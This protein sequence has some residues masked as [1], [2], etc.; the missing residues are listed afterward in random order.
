MFSSLEYQAVVLAGG[1][2]TRMSELTASKPKCLLPIGSYPMIWYSL[3]MLKRIGFKEVIVITLDSAKTEITNLPK[4]F[5][6]ELTLDVVTIPAL[7][8]SGSISSHGEEFGT[9]DAIRLIH[10][11]L[12]A[13]RIMVVSSDLVTDVQLRHLTDL[14]SVHSSSLTALF[15]HSVLDHKSVEVP[16]PK[17]KPKKERDFVGI[18]HANSQ[19]C[20]FKSEADVDGGVLSL[21]RKILQEHP[22]I[23]MYN[24]LLDAHFYIF[25]KWVCDFIKAD[26]QISTIKG[27]L[28]P[29]LVKKQFSITSNQIGK[30]ST[31]EVDDTPNPPTSIANGERNKKRK[32]R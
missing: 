16:G 8:M 14:H 23:T 28:I 15:S 18:D 6:L 13:N 26:Q 2:G 32:H 1:R 20:Y 27:E 21:G 12:K 5:D 25:D 31:N 10:D 30:A 17:S 29:K 7:S 3:N 24:N 19:L 4:K 9:A 11:K 22:K